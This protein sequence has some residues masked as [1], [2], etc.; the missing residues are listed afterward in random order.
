[1]YNKT[2]EIHQLI[3]KPNKIHITFDIFVYLGWFVYTLRIQCVN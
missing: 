1:M 3:T 2:I